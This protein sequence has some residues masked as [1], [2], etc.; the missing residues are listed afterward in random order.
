MVDIASTLT[1]AK[2][3]MWVV[4]AIFILLVFGKELRPLVD[5]LIQLIMKAVKSI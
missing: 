5:A 3:M 1:A 2:G 4:F